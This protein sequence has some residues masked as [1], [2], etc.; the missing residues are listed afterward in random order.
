MQNSKNRQ[1]EAD[2]TIISSDRLTRLMSEVISLRERVAQAELKD[3]IY[4]SP[5]DRY[6]KRDRG[7]ER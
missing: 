7:G 6:P 2:W 4:R 5:R 3:E 1:A